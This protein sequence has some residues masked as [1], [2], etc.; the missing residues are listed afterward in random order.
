MPVVTG[1]VLCEPLMAFVP[2]NPAPVAVHDVA[3]VELQV[4]VEAAPLTTA[5]GFAVSVAV[6]LGT[7]VTVAV[8]VVLVPPVPVQVRVYVVLAVRGPVL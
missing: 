7:M 5:A 2:A 6:G 3:L 8:A 4:S 1:P